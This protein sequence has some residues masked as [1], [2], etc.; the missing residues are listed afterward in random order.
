MTGVQTCALPIYSAGNFHGV[1]TGQIA[2]PLVPD[3]MVYMTN[4]TLTS[5][6]VKYLNSSTVEM[7]IGPMYKVDAIT[8]QDPYALFLCGTQ[9]VVTIENPSCDTE[10]ELYIFRDSFTS[11]LAPLL[12]PAYSK[13]TLIDLRYIDSRMLSQVVEFTPDADVLFL[14]GMQ[15]LNNPSIL[16]IN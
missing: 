15:I 12:T 1:Y 10:R 9:P 13:I 2:L 16:L 5:A 7:K 6:V 8:G 3:E 4:P 14:Y 11:S